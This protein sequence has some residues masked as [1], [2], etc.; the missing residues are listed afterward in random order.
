[1]AQLFAG[2]FKLKY[3]VSVKREKEESEERKRV[4]EV[5]E[6]LTHVKTSTGWTHLPIDDAYHLR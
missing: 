5:R 6:I 3:L 2:M 1:M 4:E